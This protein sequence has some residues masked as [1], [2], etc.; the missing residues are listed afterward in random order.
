MILTTGVAIMR[1]RI[2]WSPREGLL[3]L[4]DPDAVGYSEAALNLLANTL[5]K[6]N[7]I[8][9]PFFS[10]ILALVYAVFGGGAITIK[11]TSFC[12]GL[13]AIL[14][15]YK[16]AQDAFG[17]FYVSVISAFLYGTANYVVF[18]SL[19][20]LREELSSLILLGLIYFALVRG[21]KQR[22]NLI[23]SGVLAGMLYLTRSD[24][25][26]IATLSLL[27]YVSIS[28]FLRR[29]RV[30]AGKLLAL[31]AGFAIAALGWAWF[32]LSFWGDPFY[33]SHWIASYIYRFEFHLA[34]GPMTTNVTMIDYLFK[35]HTIGQL[36]SA[37]VA[38]MLSIA[39]FLELTAYPNL[40]GYPP[41][42][43]PLA[44]LL[45]PS[46][47]IAFL[48]GIA[49]MIKDRANWYFPFAFLV[50]LPYVAVFFGLGVFES[51]RGM[52]PFV[53]ELFVT[54]SYGFVQIWRFARSHLGAFLANLLKFVG[55][56]VL[57]AAYFGINYV[58]LL[59]WGEL[60]SERNLSIRSM[61]L[62]ALLPDIIIFSF[63]AIPCLV[64]GSYNAYNNPRCR[65]R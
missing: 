45:L 22:V 8:K 15:T 65:T 1:I 57:L 27:G 25:G 43:S 9:G 61:S 30:P 44:L 39:E 63:F 41:L 52:L 37:A 40:F 32:S 17:K 33:E 21:G 10:M 29:E 47:P 42:S 20:G 5:S 13:A 31:S 14:A 60:L 24:V 51:P 48:C 18:N 3:S 26:I 23:I 6:S 35:Y 58:Y 38:G 50:F 28:T 7:L 34:S 49:Y 62:Q 54:V 16:V 11:L 56:P 36:L 2:F 19:R 64:W 4:L 53:P 46:F 59:V 55:L 12:F